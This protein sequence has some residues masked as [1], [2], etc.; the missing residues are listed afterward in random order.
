MNDVTSEVGRPQAGRISVNIIGTE[1]F[2]EPG[3]RVHIV[4]APDGSLLDIRSVNEIPTVDVITVDFDLKLA[5]SG[6]T[7]HGSLSE[8]TAGKIE[9]V[10]Q[11]EIILGKGR[12]VEGDKRT[13][14]V[15]SH[16][17]GRIRI[18]ILITVQTES[19]IRC[20]VI[21]RVPQCNS[22]VVDGTPVHITHGGYVDIIN[23]IGVRVGAQRKNS[24]QENSKH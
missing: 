24:N 9:R 19:E 2:P 15:S 18:E 5:D 22:S 14:D 10:L 17:H 6:K 3:Q 1:H 16:G 8:N 7:K 20:S 4:G 11:Y 21:L 23:S 13:G 12:T